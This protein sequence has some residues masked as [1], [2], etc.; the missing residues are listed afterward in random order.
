MR[1]LWDYTCVVKRSTIT[2]ALRQRVRRPRP[3]RRRL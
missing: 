1:Q 3:G 2:R